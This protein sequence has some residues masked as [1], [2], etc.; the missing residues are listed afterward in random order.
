L[1]HRRL[2]D[3]GRVTALLLVYSASFTPHFVCYH[4]FDVPLYKRWYGEN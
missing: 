4:F 2:G 3:A 1:L